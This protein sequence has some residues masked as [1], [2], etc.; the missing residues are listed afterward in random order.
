VVGE[1]VPQ[2]PAGARPVALDATST[3]VDAAASSGGNVY[4]FN[5]TYRASVPAESVAFPLGF[6][7]T[8]PGRSTLYAASERHLVHGLRGGAM[9]PSPITWFTVPS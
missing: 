2:P 9:I 3:E 4:P 7:R 1:R 6:H 8:K 5:A